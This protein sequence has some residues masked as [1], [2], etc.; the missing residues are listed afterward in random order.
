M[1]GSGLADDG[2]TDVLK[3][4]NDIFKAEVPTFPT[5]EEDV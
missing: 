2:A 1:K 4:T 5:N 3:S